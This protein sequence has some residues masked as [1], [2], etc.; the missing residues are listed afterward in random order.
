MIN[1]AV[2]GVG[3]MGKHHARVFSEMK[4]ANLAA[5]CDINGIKGREIAGKFKCKFYSDYKKMIESEELDAVSV[6][7]P[8]KYHK[9]V[10]ISCIDKGM[11]VLIEK[12][13]SD[14]L[15]SARAIIDASKN[16]NVKLAVGHIER[17]NPAVR[18][19]KHII[20]GGE[21]GNITTAISRRVG[22]MPPQIRDANVI[23]DTAV[24]DI[25][26][27][28]YLFDKKPI[29]TYTIAGHALLK[30]RE[31]YA[32]ILL[33]YEGA[34]AFIQVNWITPIKIR[35][36]SV[37]GTMGYAELNYITQELT[38]FRNIVEK[39]LDT[40]E[41]VVEFS[42]PKKTSISIERQEP[43]KLELKNFIES[44]EKNESPLVT[45]TDGI[46]ALGVALDIIK[47]VR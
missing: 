15:E 25:D 7:V 20:D 5:V 23:I 9:N 18:K 10:A 17:F 47:N 33:N 46:N 37:T 11:H 8:T 3:N 31:D 16:K 34:N 42:T 29:E 40:F 44:I 14:T 35:N 30:N 43:L 28:N 13:I 4:E 41:D 6:V 45:G 36:L 2:I 19:L 22:T 24:H 12:P 26:I 21:L 1:V 27:F 39:K 38:I 32:D